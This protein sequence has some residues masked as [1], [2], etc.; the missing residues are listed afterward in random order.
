MDNQS[1]YTD[2]S[3]L[4]DKQIAEKFYPQ[5]NAPPIVAPVIPPKAAAPIL[6]PKAQAPLATPEQFRNDALNRDAAGN[7]ILE[8]SPGTFK[9]TEVKNFYDARKELMT[10]DVTK[11]TEAQATAAKDLAETVAPDYT[12]QFSD[13]YTKDI[14]PLDTQIADVKARLVPIDDALRKMDADVRAEIG[15]R[16]S[17]SSILAEVA[18]RS[19]PLE[20]QRQL[21]ADQGNNLIEQRTNA[22]S[23]VNTQLGYAKETFTAGTSL[24]KDKWTMAKGVV[25]DFNALMEKGDKATQQEVDNFQKNFTT[26]LTNSPDALRN[27]TA[28][29][30]ESLKN[31]F[32]PQSLIQK[33]VATIAEQKASGT[34]TAAQI[35]SRAAQIQS[36][37]SSQGLVMSAD[38][39][40]AQAKSEFASLGGTKTGSES[41]AG[42]VAYRTNNPGNIKWGSFAK[43]QGGVDSGIQASDGGTFAMFPD[44]TAGRTAQINLLQNSAYSPLTVDAAMKRWSNN[45]YGADIVKGVID[46]NRIMSTL[47]DTERNTLADAMQKREGWT[48]GTTAQAPAKSTKF[49]PEF[50]NS[51]LGQKVLD[52]EMQA[53]AK[54]EAN[55][56]VKDYI[57]VQDNLDSMKKIVETGAKGP[58]DLALVFAFMKALDPTSVVRESEY[59]TAAK[60][61]NIFAGWAARFNGYINEEGGFLPPN[62]RDA[63]IKIAQKRLEA[64]ALQYNNYSEKQRAIAER[65]GMNPDNVVMDFELPT[66]NPEPEIGSIIEI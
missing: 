18:R 23:N 17:E 53:K 22:L 35:L 47:T 39:A 32:V 51:T 61:G 50:Y 6:P 49:T 15:G 55:P 24:L 66:L 40:I 2:V 29:E 19:K 42:S 3:G 46:G 54:F 11:A 36:I 1:P 21:I 9:A 38:E 43:S 27:A 26:L 52:N 13:A 4:T 63:F 7:K 25:D 59:E 20:L 12:K 57:L 16:A 56:I 65:Q 8:V 45:G 28:E 5:K 58:E 33:I 41:G 60:S 64:K 48:A 37:A 62:V 14:T 30:I 34:G 44:Y 31:G 10:P